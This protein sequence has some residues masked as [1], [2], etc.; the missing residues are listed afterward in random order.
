[1]LFMEAVNDGGGGGGDRILLPFMA[2]MM[3]RCRL[4]QQRSCG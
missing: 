3:L 1:M 2:V 4:W